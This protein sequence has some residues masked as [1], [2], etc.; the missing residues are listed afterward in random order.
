MKIDF[1]FKLF[2]DQTRLRILNLLAVGKLSVTDIT[3]ILGI[4]QPKASRHLAQLRVAGLVDCER[5][6]TRAIY[7]LAKPHDQFQELLVGHVK[8]GHFRLIPVVKEDLKRAV[9]LRK[10]K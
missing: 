9:L 1:L 4:S 10:K 5:N 7:F 8:K 3:K 6:G 2:A